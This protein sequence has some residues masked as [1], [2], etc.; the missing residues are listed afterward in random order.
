MWQRIK[1]KILQINKA[2][3][4]EVVILPNGRYLVNTFTLK[5]KGN[6]IEKDD[7]VQGIKS[8]DELKCDRKTPVALVLNGKGILVKKT[9]Q[10]VTERNAVSVILPQAN[11]AEFYTQTEKYTQFSAVAIARKDLVD[12]I[13]DGLE[14]KG[15][16]VLDVSFGF[17]AIGR[18]L[19]HFKPE[20]GNELSTTGFRLTLDEKKEL[21]DFSALPGGEPDAFSQQEY[22]V[23]A[24]YIQS[25]DLLPYAAAMSLL[26]ES[27]E[28]P[29][30][31]AD[32]G[33][34]G[35]REDLKYGK[36]F[37]AASMSLLVFLFVLLLIN[38]F[39]YNH[40]FSKN[41]RFAYTQQSGEKSR[42]DQES[43]NALVKSKEGFLQQSGWDRQARTSFFA[44]RLAGF[45]PQGVWFTSLNFYP[46][47]T[48]LSDD[49]EYYFKRDTVQLTGMCYDP[50][51]INVL[52]NNIRTLEEV[53]EVSMKNYSF[54]KSEETG[55]FAL[56]LILK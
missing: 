52:M 19:P 30:S 32:D 7:R 45:L 13:V 3:G 49:K 6:T 38:F 29:P 36:Y 43:L 17:F 14:Q 31:I 37:S 27:I 54:K 28:E 23:S 46:L 9:T 47:N 50:V 26:L 8:F 40:Y 24:K 16:K 39:V 51:Q 34:A 42:K 48:T 55:S 56:E 21:E 18:L 20:K 25:F 15:F 10:P 1:E 33:V 41:G 35:A 5:V 2:T 53:Q 44:D 12:G 22:L 11:P 4:I